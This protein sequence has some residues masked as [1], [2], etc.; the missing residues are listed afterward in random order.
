MNP[1][2]QAVK[3]YKRAIS[4]VVVV[5]T[6]AVSASAYTVTQDGLNTIYE[7]EIESLSSIQAL[8]IPKGQGGIAPSFTPTMRMRA[9]L[10][11]TSNIVYYNSTSSDINIT[12]NSKRI[13]VATHSVGLGNSVSI[14]STGLP[15]FK[16]ANSDF[17]ESNIAVVTLRS[18]VELLSMKESYYTFSVD[19]STIYDF[20][21][22]TNIGETEEER[23]EIFTSACKVYLLNDNS[24]VATLSPSKMSFLT[25]GATIQNSDDFIE[26]KGD[27]RYY[28][29][30][31]VEFL[32]RN[33]VEEFE[34]DSIQF[35][36][37]CMV[38][39]SMSGIS[40]EPPYY[41][42]F[43]SVGFSNPKMEVITK[44][45]YDGM[46]IANY[47]NDNLIKQLSTVNTIDQT[48]IDSANS[49]FGGFS[50]VVGSL[51]SAEASLDTELDPSSFDTPDFVKSNVDVLSDYWSVFFGS[52]S[53][54]SPGGLFEFLRN[55]VAAVPVI[56]LLS[57]V[58]FGVGGGI[59]IKKIRGG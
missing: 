13:G 17:Y 1:K 4:F 11:G 48:R 2:S 12:L 16:T 46:V 8:I 6:L 43:Q 53:S 22:S 3:F 37:P 44:T 50:S 14:A 9:A 10:S 28:D 35:S 18:D 51:S 42:W 56:S 30:C 25:T 24:V 39:T 27:V 15:G 59:I 31:S 21:A 55:I 36:F 5:L 47:Q 7:W 58:L 26:E 38:G 32:I 52:D 41:F 19:F 33:E 54:L 40:G 45:Q 20:Y 23:L 34:I 29:R 57:T 49:S